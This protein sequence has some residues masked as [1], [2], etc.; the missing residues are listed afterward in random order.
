M[1]RLYFSK[2]R[3][4]GVIKQQSTPKAFPTKNFYALPLI[5]A[6]FLFFLGC[7]KDYLDE[8]KRTDVVPAS[9][10]F[11]SRDGVE[12]YLSGIYRL[13][14][15]Q[16]QGDNS[17]TDVGGLYSI[18]FARN[19]KGKDLIQDVS[20]YL[21]DYA[22][23]NR[24]ATYRRVRVTWQFLY[25]LINHANIL[26][27]NVGESSGLSAADKTELIAHGKALRAFLYLQLALE[28]C[29]LYSESPE[30]DAPPL[31]SEPAGFNAKAMTTQTKLYAFMIKDINDAI[32][33]LTESRIDKSYINK[34]VANAIKVQ[35][36][37]A[38]NSDWDQVEIAAREAYGGNADAALHAADYVNGFNNIEDPEWIWGMDQSAD[39]SNYYYCAPHAFTDHEADAYYAT[40][41]DSNFVNL[42]SVS[43][44]RNLFLD[45]YGETNYYKYVTS[46]FH[47]SFEA[48]IP[49]IRT[50][51][52]ILAEAEAKYHQ[53]FTNDAHDLLY[54][55]QQSRDPNAVKST[56]TGA[57]LL[58]EILVERR[59]ELYGENG[60]EWFDAK[61]L[62][63]S[64]VRGPNHRVSL[65]L[66]A[67]DKRFFLKIPQ[68]EIDNNDSITEAVNADR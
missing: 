22:H 10:V 16:Y 3:N 12:A 52:M 47:F 41:V 14:R 34:S 60:V 8:P 17:V 46:K 31:Y 32:E 37:M 51:E 53:G 39:Q 36:L 48:D 68:A 57:Q 45:L 49:I 19:V 20:W 43:D 66:D 56:N 29:P 59:K 5:F 23:E 63:R 24:E 28:Y 50:S 11:S 61:R 7:S 58:D 25:D 35:I 21:F 40:F 67:N 64:I 65:S 54:K 1:N 33:G 30:Y 27:K 44:V 26:I 38:M 13:F 15:Y 42:F 18:F 4:Q 9:T 6:G 62:Q 2:N 55:L